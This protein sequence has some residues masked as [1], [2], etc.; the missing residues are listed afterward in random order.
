MRKLLFDLF[1]YPKY[2]LEDVFTPASAAEV[3]YII[4]KEKDAQLQNEMSTP[5]KQ[6]IVFGHS[7][8]GKTSSVRN[9]LRTGNLSHIKTHCESSTTFEQI[10]LNA[11]DNLDKFVVSE[12]SMIKHHSFSK[13]LAAEYTILKSSIGSSNYTE[14]SNVSTRLLTPQLTP[15]KLAQFMGE[16]NIIWIIEDFH[17]V[18]PKEKARIADVIKIFA[19]NS[20]DYRISKVICIGACESAHELITLNP[21]LKARVSE[22]SVPLLKDEEIKKIIINGFYLLNVNPSTSLID[23]LVY[24]SDRLGAFAHQMCMD[25][26]KGEGINKTAFRKRFIGDES[27]QYAI[28]GFINRSSDTLK[29]IYDAAVKNELGWYILKTF[30]GNSKEK[31]PIN[32]IC[33]IVNSSKKNFT[34]EEIEDKLRE[35]MSPSFNI[36]YY[37]QNSEKY[38]LST[39]FWHR[40]LRL[41]FSLERAQ[42]KKKKKNN[43]NP[44]L[45]LA[46]KE[47]KFIL[48]DEY[49]LEFI[50]RLESSKK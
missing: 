25:I 23:K 50:K 33:N 40:F 36:I 18:A 30:S 14:E 20:N 15:Q 7:G 37:N 26:C 11:F 29:S 39:P 17:K 32:E 6:I 35:L 27:F 3:N 24:Y 38:A 48:V 2:H 10:L 49:L 19:D 13:N 46:G 43:R 44:N 45:S 4:R 9:L 28:N 22:V 8:S 12:K 42:K 47:D 31:L 16:G 5:G 21:D 41:Q 34:R 1:K